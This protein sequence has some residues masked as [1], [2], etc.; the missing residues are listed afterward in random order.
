MRNS[1]GACRAPVQSRAFTTIL[2]NKRR[3]TLLS[4]LLSAGLLHAQ[5]SPSSPDINQMIQNAVSKG[6]SSS[7]AVPLKDP[8]AVVNG[9]SITKAELAKNF[10]DAL[11]ASGQ[12][13]AT[14]TPEQKM[15]GYCQILDGMIMEKLVNKQAA[16]VPVEKAEVEAQL[17]E[18]QE[19]VSVRGGL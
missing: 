6:G 14:L 18:D 1:T 5:N 19:A 11:V 4:I 17:E 9:E 16:N 2:M 15:Q 12:N 13:P 10:N 7:P 8:I 3:L